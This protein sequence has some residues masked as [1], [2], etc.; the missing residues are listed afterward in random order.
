MSQAADGV[1]LTVRPARRGDDGRG[2]VRVPS[3]VQS[4]LG[5]VTG[6]PVLVEGDGVAVATVWPAERGETAVRVDDDTR[7]RAGATVGERVVLRRADVE[8]AERIRLRTDAS[9][10]P[11]ARTV[12]R[13]LEERVLQRGAT[14][15]VP[16]Q[17][18]FEVLETR[19]DGAVRVTPR[20]AVD[21][22]VTEPGEVDG[23]TADEPAQGAPDADPGAAARDR[24]TTYEDVGGL[25]AELERVREVIELPL[26]K[27]ER[28]ERIG[29]EPPS[30][31]LLYGP[32]GTG[33]T[34]IAKAVATE[35]EAAFF[36]IAGPEIVSKYKG[37]S[38]ERLRETFEAAAAEAP[39]IVFVDEID[40]IAGAR[41]DD[42][43]MENR[44]VAQL[45]TLMDGLATTEPI[46][47]IGATNRVDA[48]DPALRRGG[49]FERE[50][51]IGVP[52]EAGRREILA[53]HADSAPLAPA[54]D[55]DDLAAR[56]HGYVGADLATLVREAALRALREDREPLELRS[57]DFEAALSA[58]EP[59]AMRDAA[60]EQPTVTFEDVG[61]LDA[62][63]RGLREAVEWPLAYRPL[64]DAAGTEPPTGVLLH[65]PSGTGKTLLAR[66][67]AGESRVNLVRVEGPSLLDRYVGE[68]EAALRSVFETARRAAPAVVFV[69]DVDAVAGRRDQAGE[70]TDRAVSQLLAELDRA[71]EHPDLV[72]LAA[73]TRPDALDPGLTRA[74][75]FEREI[76]VS[77]PDE[78]DRREILS[79]HAEGKPL[80]D[81]VDLD[82]LAAATADY[83]GADL[84]AVVR[85]AAV[86]A[87]RDVASTVE[88]AAATEHADDVTVEARHFQAALEQESPAASDRPGDTTRGDADLR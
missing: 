61:G 33:K 51:E 10:A 9:P 4:T 24:G 44:I 63:K 87:V 6:D 54:V 79:I 35:A 5:V 77:L 21:V 32:P 64:Y 11:P 43:D 39:A 2:I 25:D 23:K 41:G 57:A 53:V 13:A 40:A 20:T 8:S 74:G 66:A 49:R 50:I 58:L 85:E 59:T 34:L 55:L 30:G 42:R 18:R 72:V 60:A 29:V 84:A 47:V 73:T 68:T 7:S 17:G 56:T 45:L 15:R 78:A 22:T 88:P 83:T 82:D 26:A 62:A 27:P 38:A 81:D 69:D 28:F 80:G 48:V 37:E 70:V 65:G 75:R 86:R 52:E 14:V 12:E 31:V 46:V 3:D 36:S 1:D 76:E 19:P 71:A 16:G 67:A